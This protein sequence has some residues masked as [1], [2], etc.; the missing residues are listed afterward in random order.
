[1][2]WVPPAKYRPP[3]AGDMNCDVCVVGGG[4]TGLSAAM[5]LAA[6]GARVTLLEAMSAGFAASGRNGGQIHIGFRREQANL[7]KWLGT[8]HAHDLWR[9]S[10]EA[11]TQLS[12]LITANDISC[13]LRSGI[14]LAAHSAAALRS[15][16]RDAEQ[17]D[18]HY[19]H[20]TKILDAGQAS[21]IVGS[22]QYV[23]GRLDE[24]GGSLH[25]MKFARGLADAAEQHGVLIHESTP[26]RSIVRQQ[27]PQVR[28][29]GGIISADHVILACDAFSG[30]LAPELA[31]FI[32]HIE[33]FQIATASLAAGLRRAILPGDIAVAD[34]RFAP[35][36]YRMTPGGKLVFGGGEHYWPRPGDNALP[37]R[38]RLAAVF[39]QLAGVKIDHAWRGTIGVTRT[40]MPH[41]GMLSQRIYFAH[42]YSG[43]GLALSLLY[44]KAMAEAVLG[45][46]ER[47]E[48][49][50]RIPA[51][52]F[53]GGATMRKPLMAAGL[54]FHK[55]LDAI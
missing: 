52:P 6:K 51:A 3:L 34:T 22:T 37:V 24:H 36:Y 46:S 29:D 55:M 47:F 11:R 41:A 21:S 42:G 40:R 45:N 18:R 43:H 35:D 13:D 28:C 12:S 48:I 5:H 17:L 32:G 16:A 9:L 14:F 2:D 27:K 8:E 31:Q 38:S 44:G 4:Y 54:L 10:E 1:M 26:A 23:G 53:P 15:L 33:S 50:T 25:P 39:P 49:L 30:S 19:G 7:E 20:S